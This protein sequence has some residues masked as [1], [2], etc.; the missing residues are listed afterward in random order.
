MVAGTGRW[1]EHMRETQ[2]QEASLVPVT[3]APQAQLK[4][5]QAAANIVFGWGGVVGISLG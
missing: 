4:M 5:R 1:S 3:R 2:D